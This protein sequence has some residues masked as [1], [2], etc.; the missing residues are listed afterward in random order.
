MLLPAS[1]LKVS[2]SLSSFLM[3]SLAFLMSPTNWDT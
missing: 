3:E 2:I 1:L